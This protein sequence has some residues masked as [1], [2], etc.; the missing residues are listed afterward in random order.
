MLIHNIDPVA[1]SFFIFEIR[2][3]SL[4]YIFGIIL[5]WYYAKKIVNKLKSK[6]GN[7]QEL[8]SRDF[9]DLIP[10]LIMGIILGGRLGYVFIYNLE[11][12]L[13][14]LIKI[15]FIWEGGMSFHGGLI[16]VI[17]TIFIFSKKKNI[18]IF[19]FLD[20]ISIVAPIGLFFGRIANFINAE[21]YGKATDAPWGVIFSNVDKIPRH[22]S[23]IYE[24]F[25]EGLLLFLLLSFLAFKKKLIFK[26][27]IIS[28]IFL[29]FYSLFRF[30][31]EFFRE[32][33][34]HVGYLYL[35]TTMGQVLSLIMLFCGLILISIL[36]EKKN[37]L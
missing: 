26:H 4:A 16:G 23:Q 12:Y 6:N 37:E 21:L 2:W 3:Y 33:D 25:L 19:Y 29:T 32:P 18:N 36:I 30:I 8:N 1:I 24:A 10:Y 15:F 31:S 9:D 20:I 5:G 27:G 13:E 11:Y 7:F 17:F 22:P 35:G 28:G 14:N 34:V